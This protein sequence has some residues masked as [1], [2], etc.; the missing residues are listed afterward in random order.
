MVSP[1]LKVPAC[2][3]RGLLRIPP[4]TQLTPVF[5]YIVIAFHIRPSLEEPASLFFS[6][7]IRFPSDDFAPNSVNLCKNRHRHSKLSATQSCC[8]C[9]NSAATQGAAP[10]NILPARSPAWITSATDDHRGAYPPQVLLRTC[11][12]KAKIPRT[13]PTE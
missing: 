12:A 10:T 1:S 8:T 5:I 11:Q 9:L 4:N 7:G 3:Q 2:T 13:S 6:N